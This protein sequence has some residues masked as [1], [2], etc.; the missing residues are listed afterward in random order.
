MHQIIIPQKHEEDHR[1]NM[2]C[3]GGP[4]QYALIKERCVC[5]SFYFYCLKEEIKHIRKTDS[6]A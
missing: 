1:N 2:G 6:S 5:V 4:P 3:M